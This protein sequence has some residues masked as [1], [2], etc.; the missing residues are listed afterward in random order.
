VT[1][2]GRPAFLHGVSLFDGLGPT[3]P[4]DVDLDTL[5]SWGINTV[6]VWA[7][8]HG[9]IYQADGALSASGAARLTALVRQL[10]AR[11]MV[12]ELVLLRP[13]Q[14]PGQRYA[15]FASEDARLRAV[16]AITTALREYRNVLF[17]LYNEHDH[18]DGP[19][20]HQAARAIRDRVKAID[21]DRLVTISSTEAHLIGSNGMMDDEQRKN[22]REEAGTQPDAVNVDIVAVHLPRSSDWA[23]A[24]GGRVTALRAALQAVG[25]ALPVYL[26][27]ERRS[28]EEKTLPADEYATARAGA[29][30]AGATGWVF[31]TDAGYELNKRPFL[32]ALR[33]QERA[34]LAGLSR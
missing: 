30:K 17:D 29:E 9:P 8:W 22:L 32:D 28:E 33:P 7:H 5:K 27:E 19:I 34:G 16:E 14:L 12:L 21:R 11:A 13:G 4:R 3:A 10:Q 18:P 25:R 2:D 6:R 31:H 1:L 15:I 23:A 20:S 26:N 24:T